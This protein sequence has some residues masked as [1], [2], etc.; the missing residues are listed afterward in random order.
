MGNSDMADYDLFDVI[1]EIG[2]GQA[3]KTM[4]ERAEAFEYKHEQWLESIPEAPANVIR[5]IASQF[6]K[7][8]TDNLENPEILNT[9]EVVQAGG[10]VALRQ[11]VDGGAAQAF[12]ETKRRMFSA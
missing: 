4:T 8:G 5:A 9:P 1:A 10:R 7:G 12:S 3:P 6:S 2:Y 11:Y